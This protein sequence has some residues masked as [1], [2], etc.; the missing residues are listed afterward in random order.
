[1]LDCYD[2]AMLL[3]AVV[4]LA[5]NLFAS[6]D[7][8]FLLGGD[9]VFRWMYAQRELYGEQVYR[10]FMQFTPPG[11]DLVYLGLFRLFGPRIWVPNLIVMLLGLLLTWLSLRLARTIMRPAQAMLAVALLL[12]LVYGKLLNGTHYWFSLPFVLGAILL[13]QESPTLAR[14]A[15]AGAL[16]GAA[17]FFTQT[18]GPAAALAVSGVM[19]LERYR[20]QDPWPAYLQ[21]Q[22]LLLAAMITTWLALSGYYIV[23][24]GPRQLWF[25]QVTYVRQYVGTGAWWPQS[26]RPP[27]SFALRELSAGFETLLAYGVLPLVYAVSLWRC[28]KYR[29]EASSKV[30]ACSAML[31]MV[32]IAMFFEVAPGSNWFRVYCGSA[33]GILLLVWLASGPSKLS[34]YAARLAWVGVLGLAAHQTWAR[35]LEAPVIQQ[36]PAGRLAATPIA[37]EKLAWLAAHTRPGQF[38][39]QA[40]WPGLYLPLALRNP[41]F[42]EDL[43]GYRENLYIPRSKHELQAKHVQYVMWSPR[44]ESPRYPLGELREF[45]H[46]QYHKVWTFSDHDEIWELNPDS[47]PATARR[48]DS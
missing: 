10:D 41:I 12:V 42:L 28:W 9:Q 32:G 21:R 33:P 27:G 7:T 23:T 15:L 3:G 46:A 36:L 26:V 24:V 43:D 37:G 1:M 48:P 8:P 22:L 35:H 6:L 45:L 34:A 29:H 40:G 5:A 14:T 30:W 20:M 11:T 18:R 2:I 19:L 44:L 38:F 39:L 4:Y 47:G 25:F 13:L 16:L 31:A 17:S